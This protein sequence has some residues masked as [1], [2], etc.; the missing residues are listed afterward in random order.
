MAKKYLIYLSILLLISC[1]KNINDNEIAGSSDNNITEEKITIDETGE[2]NIPNNIWGEKLVNFPEGL[3][4]KKEPGLNSE[5]IMVIP[6]NAVVYLIA[7]DLK[8]E[9]ID[10]IN[11]RWYFV[12]YGEYSGW[13][14]GGYLIDTNKDGIT[15]YL[16]FKMILKEDPN[17][18][19]R[20]IFESV[21]VNLT[22]DM[23]RVEN[24]MIDN[25]TLFRLTQINEEDYLFEYNYPPISRININPDSRNV[26]I[27]ENFSAPFYTNSAEKG[28]G[29]TD[30]KFSLIENKLI[31][32]LTH[33]QTD[34]SKIDGDV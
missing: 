33:Q 11:D 29:Y 26:I 18:K 10:N 16:D 31:L 3:N 22:K 13:V 20:F 25:N 23:N 30:I 21:L 28:G 12:Q 27:N 5:K 4:L 32:E 24:Y 2:T 15:E 19:G 14:F 17:D 9:T 8:N 34:M 6:H 7:K 1:S